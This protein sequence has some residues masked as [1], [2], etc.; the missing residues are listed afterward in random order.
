MSAAGTAAEAPQDPATPPGALAA[1]LAAGRDFPGIGPGLAARLDQHFGSD[2]HAAMTRRDPGV[3][4]ILGPVVAETAF[5][6]FEALAAEAAL[7][8]WLDRGG[9]ARKVGAAT[10]IRIAR[11]WGP[12]GAAALA[13]NPYLLVAF[14][15]WG[16]VERVGRALGVPPDDP[17]RQA[18]AVE[19]SLYAALERNDTVVAVPVLA[20]QVSRLLRC[21]P[22]VAVS[23][24][25]LAVRTGGACRIGDGV[26]PVGAA[27][28]EDDIA[29]WALAAGASEPVG[30][31]FA[32][33][34][35][36]AEI[37]A[38]ITAWTQRAP[39]PPTDGQRQ[40][41]RLALTR[42]LTTLAGYAGTG[43]TASLRS[44]CE[45][46]AELG[47]DTHLIA[48]AGRAAQRMAEATGQPAR[49][50]AGFL[51]GH[52]GTDG[53]AL[54]AHAL[55]IVD[56][57]SMVDLPTMWRL[58]RALGDAS[59]VL[60][61]DPAQLPPI[62]FGLVFHALCGVGGVPSVVLDTIL[63][64]RAE[65]GI[66]AVAEAIR[67]GRVPVLPPF[68]G[69]AEGVSFVEASPSGMID[70]ITRIGRRLHADG[71]VAGDT[72]IIAPVKA[73]PAGIDAIN[74]HFHR[75]RRERGTAA[76]FPGRSDIAVGDPV[77][78]TRNDWERGLM[79]GS[80]GRV[81][82]VTGASAR[83]VMDGT[84]H[85]LGAADAGDIELAYAISVHKAQGSQWRRIVMPVLSSRLLGRSLLYT[86][87]TRA[88]EQV[89]LIGNQADLESAAISL[90]SNRRRSTGLGM[91][92]D[93][94]SAGA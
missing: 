92:I 94:A 30:T 62:G 5:A 23:A 61:G 56:E 21:D 29:R 59:L 13:A 15:P 24:I 65:T 49:T 70:A 36:S 3:V 60:V 18:A 64:Q 42:R 79:N 17:G 85:E 46:A 63:R 40:A 77:I 47:R 81:M 80:M 93:F 41:I 78:W 73:G 14:L 74:R 45:I 4:A 57:A 9:V 54:P 50:I 34:P 90:S 75:M 19:A 11:C 43:K 66:P 87:I 16:L 82:S 35:S 1:W 53:P 22:A 8:D 2:L 38:R 88:A 33:T 68:T 28:M 6:A 7:L 76:L 55:V 51:Q 10:A 20:E 32:R 83:V 91:R 25:D 84:T 89:I 67:F 44:I 86:A 71:A 48:L 72:Q 12:A 39:Y 52:S 58:V 69:L 26:Q 27:R 37:D 31:L